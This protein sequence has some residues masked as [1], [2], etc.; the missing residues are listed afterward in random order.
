MIKVSSAFLYQV[1][2]MMTILPPLGALRRPLII[3]SPR[4]TEHSI[5]TYHPECPERSEVLHQMAQRMHDQG[6]VELRLPSA[7]VDLERFREAERVVRTVHS[8]EYVDEIRFLC[9]KGA[10][11]PS[12]WDMDTYLSP[13]SFETCL[14]A[15]SAWMDAVD[16][17][18]TGSKAA[19][20]LA[21]PPGHHAERSQSMGFCIFNFAAGAAKY[22][23][24]KYSL[25][26]VGILDFDVHFGNGIADILCKEPNIR[27][28]PS[29]LVFVLIYSY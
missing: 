28:I 18:M 22:A 17:V 14:L 29:L 20:A 13:A 4:F 9:A 8:N 23:L 7:E 2:L 10:R 26:R 15:Q 19:F 5:N 12:P 11:R 24:E 27:C 1:L 6:Q 25:K 3:S 21:R 16:A